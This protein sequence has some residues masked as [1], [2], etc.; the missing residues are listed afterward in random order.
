MDAL[1]YYRVGRTTLPRGVPLRVAVGMSGGRGPSSRSPEG[2]ENHPNLLLV[3]TETAREEEEER[4]D[5]ATSGFEPS[6]ASA[7]GRFL[8]EVPTGSL[9]AGP[10]E[11]LIRV[12]DEERVHFGEEIWILEREDY[13]A[14]LDEALDEEFLPSP[15]LHGGPAA[16]DYVED[17]IRERLLEDDFGVEN[18]HLRFRRDVPEGIAENPFP[19]SP[20][21]WATERLVDEFRDVA[22]FGVR[23]VSWTVELTGNR[24]GLRCDGELL[25]PLSDAAVGGLLAE[26]GVRPFLSVSGESR[27][28]D[29]TLE[30]GGGSRRFSLGVSHSIDDVAIAAEAE[31]VRDDVAQ[32]AREWTEAVKNSF[33]TLAD[34]TVTLQESNLKLTQN[35]FQQFVEQLRS[36]AEGNRQV[37]QTLQQQGQRQQQAFETLASESANAYSDFLNSALSFYQ[38]TLQQATEV[39]QGNLQQVGQVAQ[40]G[41]QASSR[42]AQSTTQAATQAGQQNAQAANQAAQ[43]SADAA[44]QAAQDSA[45]AAGE[46][47]SR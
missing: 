16:A 47:T 33:Q 24:Y 15:S 17:L 3:P 28:P 26:G 39:A 40:Q 9:A 42:A 13:R 19:L 12:G 37:T 10:F 21:R 43:E 35:F 31:V 45:D 2:V 4:R 30:V 25:E 1:S 22:L 8:F 38:Q 18:S 20:I 6:R 14:L 7:D 44:G 41:I 23:D 32:A 46:R 34:R 36:Q 27:E 29:V 11:L 5:A